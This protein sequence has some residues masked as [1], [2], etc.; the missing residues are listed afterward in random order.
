MTDVFTIEDIGYAAKEVERQGDPAIAVYH[1]LVAMHWL[2]D[3]V[4]EG[5]VSRYHLGIEDIMVLGYSVKPM[6]NTLSG[7]GNIRKTEVMFADGGEASIAQEVPFRLE[8]YV[9]NWPDMDADEAYQEFE[10]IHPFKDGNG[11]V[12][13]LLFNLKAG[14]LSKPILSPE[15]KK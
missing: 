5:K 12:G 11:R 13:S 14:S 7:E 2:R 1:M 10:Y 15:Y 3:A 6:V 8:R 4:L 9:E